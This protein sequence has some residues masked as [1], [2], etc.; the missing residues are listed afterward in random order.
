MN[1]PGP[2]SVLWSTILFRVAMLLVLLAALAVAF[3]P[4]LANLFS[5]EP[6]LTTSGDP[7][8]IRLI[9]VVPDGDDVLLD[10]RGKEI[11]GVK[12]EWPGKRTY[13]WP[14]GT[15][16]REFLFELGPGQENLDFNPHIPVVSCLAQGR[17][18]IPNTSCSLDNDGLLTS[19]GCRRLLF[20]VM[21][22][23]SY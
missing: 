23:Q 21:M 5:P 3:A 15:M 22:D 8:D 2:K 10:A 9:S 18:W 11:P 1:E 20:R 14:Q 6:R 16:L 7:A 19:D 13:T 4:K 17:S 12:F